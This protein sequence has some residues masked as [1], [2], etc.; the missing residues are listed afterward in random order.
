MLKR[1]K[2]LKTISTTSGFKRVQIRLAIIM[3]VTLVEFL[4]F[5]LPTFVVIATILVQLHQ[6]SV[7]LANEAWSVCIMLKLV[8]CVINPLWTTILPKKK[9]T[10]IGTEH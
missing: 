8:D 4:L 10:M 3:S 1:E 9:P 5:Q 7:T 6:G 2:A